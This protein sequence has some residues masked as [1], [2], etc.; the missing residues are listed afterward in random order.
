MA[1]SEV[2]PIAITA[3]DGTGSAFSSLKHNVTDADSVLKTLQSSFDKLSSGSIGGL[4]S[5]GSA[6]KMLANPYVALTAVVLGLSTSSILAAQ[7]LVKVGA[8]AQSIGTKGSNI[9]GL[10]EELKKVGGDSDVAIA[11]LKNLRTQ[12]DLNSRDGGY[13]EKLFKLNGSSI[14]DAAGQL[15]PIND[16]YQELAGF[17]RNAKN[18]TESLEIATNAFGNEAAPAMKKAIDAG[19]TSLASLGKADLDPLIQQSREVDRI[20]TNISNTNKGSWWSDLMNG[21]ATGG[22]NIKLAA[23]ALM[24]SQEAINARKRLNNPDAYAAD[25]ETYQPFKAD[26]STGT[27]TP[28]DK[29]TTVTP[30]SRPDN[31]ASTGAFDRA[32]VSVAKHTAEVLADTAAVDLGAGALAEMQSEA[33]LLA[34]AQESGLTV[35]QKMRDKIQDLAQDAG[36]AASALAKAKAASEINFARGTAFLT[37]E[38]LQIAQA[39]KPIYGTDIPAAL[40]STEAAALRV[41]N[42][43]KAVSDLGQDV[44]RGIFVDFTTN[45][46]NGVGLWDSFKNAGVNALGKVS[47][48]LSSM[49]ADQLWKAAFGGTGGGGITSL[50]GNLFGGSNPNGGGTVLAGSTGN[51][52]VGGYSMPQ[53]AGGTDSAPGGLAM[54]N[55]NGRGEIV[56]LPS[57]SRVIPHDVSMEMARQSSGSSGGQMQV[58]IGVSVDPNGNLQA[59][60]KSVSR[61]EAAGAVSDFAGSSQFVAAAVTGVKSHVKRN[62]QNLARAFAT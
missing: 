2:L 15:K 30:S 47:D 22:N 20:W 36:D 46:R 23:A 33:K 53:F 45:L 42:A 24:G 52:N 11:G 14:T 61:S 28:P 25:N 34:T 7:E 16:I 17:I 1:T 5:L 26:G 40:N 43:F 4:S 19:V 12:L 50:F 18:E 44:N 57:G 29:K 58:G 35:T 39:L 31:S 56:D 6:A 55:E 62:N 8:A 10:G 48:K 60:V 3:T 54:I 49:A 59:Y 51:I 21:L 9:E 32:T 38:D 37:P 13:L 41:N 27:Y